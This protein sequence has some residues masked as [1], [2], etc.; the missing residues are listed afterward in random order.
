M[1][2]NT[3]NRLLCLMFRAINVCVKQRKEITMDVAFG[4][5][6]RNTKTGEIGLLIKTY[7]N[8]FADKNVMYAVWVDV[9]GKRKCDELDNLKPLE[10]ED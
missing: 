9:N 8:E 3:A 2:Q 1:L 6:I 4:T 5:K 10:D 7:L